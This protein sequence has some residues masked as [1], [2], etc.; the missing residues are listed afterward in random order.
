[1]T[2]PQMWLMMANRW[3]TRRRQKRAD[4]YLPI[5]R[6]DQPSPSSRRL[7][8]EA[9]TDDR[10]IVQW[11]RLQCRVYQMQATSVANQHLQHTQ[12]QP[13]RKMQSAL[14]HPTARTECHQPG[15]TTKKR[16]HPRPLPPASSST[17]KAAVIPRPNLS[18]RQS[19]YESDV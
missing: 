12:L 6:Y 7:H 14:H 2:Y 18:R 9:L 4:D 10:C 13:S 3:L 17:A 19:K 5:M 16:P 15:V 8:R 11:I 1:M